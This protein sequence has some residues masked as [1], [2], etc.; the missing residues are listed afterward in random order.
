MTQN[1]PKHIAIILDGNRRYAK[2]LGIPKFKGHE[3]G[4]NKIKELLE[5][6]LPCLC[7]SF[8]ELF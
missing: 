2:K 7:Q 4:F 8:E 5:L 6:L 1:N 3:K